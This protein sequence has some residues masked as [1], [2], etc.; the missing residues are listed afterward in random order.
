MKCSGSI[1]YS[2]IHFIII[3]S[4]FSCVKNGSVTSVAYDLNYGDSILFLRPSSGDYIVYP[5]TQRNGVYSGFPEGIEIDDKTGAI[6]VSKSETGLRYRITHTA[7]DGTIT[8]TKVVLSGITYFDQFYRLSQNDTISFPAYN[9]SGTNPLPVAGSIF[10]DGGGANS[11]G[12]D[13]KTINGQ[14]NLAQTVR[15]GLFGSNPAN[16]SRRDIEIVYRLNDGSGKTLNKLKVRLYYYTSMAT[17][18]LDLLQ[19][20]AERQNGG[21]FLRGGGIARTEQAARPRPPCVIIIAN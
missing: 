7:P 10:D 15:N 5:K 18:A 9:A 11:S 1:L 3:L 4:L 21:V 19:T 8:T 6:N 20:L 14:I 2:T 17:V 16:D 13:V 12:C